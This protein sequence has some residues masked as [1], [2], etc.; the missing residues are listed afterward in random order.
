MD[1]ETTRVDYILAVDT[2]DIDLA[3]KKTKILNSEIERQNKL[4]KIR[5]REE[6]TKAY[7]DSLSAKKLV[8]KQNSI[9]KRKLNR[10]KINS[11]YAKS[12][13]SARRTSIMEDKIASD[14]AFKYDKLASTE[15]LRNRDLDI[16]EY[17][18]LEKA[19]ND[20]INTARKER[21]SVEKANRENE[22]A[23]NIR[24]E[25]ARKEQEFKTKHAFAEKKESNRQNEF[26]KQLK[27]REKM[28]SRDQILQARRLAHAEK[29]LAHETEK[30]AVQRQQ[31]ARL[32]K[33]QRRAGRGS[34]RPF[35]SLMMMLGSFMLLQ[36][37]VQM[38]F[39]WAGSLGDAMAN[40]ETDTRKGRAYR[41]S[42]TNKG[43]STKN[44][45]TAVSTFSEMS[46]EQGYM[47]RARMA[48]IYG[49]L[50]QSGINAS[51]LNPKA[52][53]EVLQGL[54]A[55]MGMSDEQAD[56]KLAEILAN[57][58]S[59]EDKKMFG[60]KSRT[61]MQILEEMN[62]TFHNNPVIASTLRTESATS[63]MKFIRGARNEL[64]SQIDDLWGNLF[65]SITGPMKEFTKTFFGLD[66]EHVKAE[67]ITTLSTI[68]D[69]VEKV[70]T[71]ENAE[72]IA[73]FT[74][75]FISGISMILG[76]ISS[77]VLNHPWLS[78]GLGT[79]GLINKSRTGSFFHF[80]DNDGKYDSNVKKVYV[81]NM[82]NL[83]TE[84]AKAGIIVS[85][86]KT[87]S[88]FLAAAVGGAILGAM[89]GKGIANWFQ[90][91]EDKH[92]ADE[93]LRYAGVSR[94]DRH[95]FKRRFEKGE[96]I[97][98]E[99]YI[100]DSLTEKEYQKYLDN[101][102]N[103]IKALHDVIRDTAPHLQSPSLQG[104]Y[105][106]PNI[107]FPEVTENTSPK[108]ETHIV[109]T[110]VYLNNGDYELDTIMNGARGYRF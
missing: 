50:G 84:T 8:D 95:E 18:A 47:A 40:V 54:T 98:V 62:A 3:L 65:T 78:A 94:K 90:S 10:A 105:P 2:E 89:A 34:R 38:P 22:K 27:S 20:R 32:E 16:R 68:R 79:I 76:S 82:P 103:D 46:G 101:K 92:A 57:R 25:T 88:P 86:L 12:Q 70:F 39:L 33:L 107:A 44:F 87:A 21:E 1:N 49:Q 58:I 4:S 109:A 85:A 96:K 51:Q 69:Q 59:K 53:A 83:P 17:A 11:M 64:F 41:N 14:Y 99:Q 56:K 23:A 52:M 77:F 15:K 29:K 75:R 7:V 97:D 63:H 55:G 48:R 102:S 37:A 30:L 74:N 9:D 19:E 28:K 67:W 66:N 71:K 31:Q 26:D 80:S 36:Y 104:F 61:P 6:R 42:L 72:K 5:T 24:L 91:N 81:T 13:D 100:K 93:R 106:H 110:N 35:E 60:I 45:D 108:A 73:T 43:V